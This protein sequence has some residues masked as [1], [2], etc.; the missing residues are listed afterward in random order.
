MIAKPL[1]LLLCGEIPRKKSKRK[2]TNYSNK[3]NTWKWSSVEQ[4][5]FD[6]LKEA[7][8]SPPVL[9]YTDSSL[10]FQLSVDASSNGLGSVLYQTHNGQQKVFAYASRGLSKSEKNYSVHKLEFLALKWSV[11]DKFRDYIGSNK[12]TVYTDNN[13]LTYVLSSAKLDCTG[14]RWLADLANFDLELKYKTGKTNVDADCLSR[15]SCQVEEHLD[16]QFTEF[17]P[18]QWKIAQRKDPVIGPFVRFVTEKSKPNIKQVS[19][20]TESKNTPHTI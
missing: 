7:L 12:C 3:P 19:N 20:N 15:L 9:G 4:E 13:P 16:G 11:L 1:N 18:M 17:D 14:H 6:K 5:S 10:P 8:T 2:L